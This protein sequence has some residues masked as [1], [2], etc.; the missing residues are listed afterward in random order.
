LYI[1]VTNAAGI[2]VDSLSRYRSSQSQI[3]TPNAWTT[4]AGSGTTVD[5]VSSATWVGTKTFT[6][7]LKD[8]TG[9]LV[10]PGTYTVHILGFTKAGSPNNVE[11]K[12]TVALGITAAL[13]TTANFSPLNASLV[14]AG[15][16]TYTAP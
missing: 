15:S 14:S 5:G 9:V 1:W 2:Y 4:A 16:V 12:A 13:R 3:I 7:D 11:T 8:H 6:W 10:A